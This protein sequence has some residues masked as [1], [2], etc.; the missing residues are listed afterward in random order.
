MISN[1]Y[2]VLF[3]LMSRDNLYSTRYTISKL[4]AIG[5]LFCG[6][7]AAFESNG[8]FDGE[9]EVYSARH[10]KH[11]RDGLR[12]EAGILYQLR[13]AEH[14]VQLEGLYDGLRQS[15]LVTDFLC[16]GDLCERVSSPNFIL[17]E[18]KCKRFVKQICQGKSSQ[19]LIQDQFF[20]RKFY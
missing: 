19:M 7:V 11:C 12:I 6:Q 3:C 18:S 20:I 8:H 14:V 5:L 15:V 16:G 2:I 17:N 4:V 10:V 13:N 9:S 1:L